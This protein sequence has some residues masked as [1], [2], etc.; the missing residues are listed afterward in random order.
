[1]ISDA[2]GIYYAAP[3]VLPSKHTILLE[4]FQIV[5][6]F[7]SN[8][9][10][11]KCCRNILTICML[12]LSIDGTEGIPSVPSIDSGNDILRLSIDICCYVLCV[13]NYP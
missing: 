10:L 11:Y 4:Y 6:R 2:G 9:I 7:L 3:S 12:L 13:E 8:N 5:T 1:M